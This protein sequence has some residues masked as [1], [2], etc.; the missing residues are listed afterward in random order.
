[1][2]DTAIALAAL[3]TYALIVTWAYRIQGNQLHEETRKARKLE[4]TKFVANEFPYPPNTH[5]NCRCA[6]VP[7]MTINYMRINGQNTRR[8]TIGKNPFS[9]N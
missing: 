2:T 8:Y 1:M 6:P 9:V 7:P 4:G 3:I 5:S